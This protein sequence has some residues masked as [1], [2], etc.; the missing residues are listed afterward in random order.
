MEDFA[1]RGGLVASTALLAS[2]FGAI[3]FSRIAA[4]AA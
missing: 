2:D 3:L 1:D 4:Q